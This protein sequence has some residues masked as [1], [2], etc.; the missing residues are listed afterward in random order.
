ME[1]NTYR[2]I[3]DLGETFLVCCGFSLKVI[4]RQICKPP[5]VHFP[6]VWEKETSTIWPQ[7]RNRRSYHR[8]AGVCRK[9]FSIKILKNYHT[10]LAKNTEFWF[11]ILVLFLH[12]LCFHRNFSG[13][14]HRFQ[15]TTPHLSERFFGYFVCSCVYSVRFW[16]TSC[17][18]PKLRL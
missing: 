12:N 3:N 2:I 18:E 1:E 15:L 13:L 8:A 14:I 10:E 16:N 6:L 7:F 5:K 17:K 4:N 11:E 9:T